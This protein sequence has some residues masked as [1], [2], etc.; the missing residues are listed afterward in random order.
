VEALPGQRRRDPGLENRRVDRLGEVVRG[1]HLEAADDAVELVDAGDHDDRQVLQGGVRS[2]RRQH[3]VAVHLRHDDVEEDHVDRRRGRVAEALERFASVR[4]LDR[5]MA[6]PP[7]Q[8]REQLPVEGRVVDDED[9]PGQGDAVA[10]GWGHAGPPVVAAVAAEV[11]R[12]RAIAASSSS[13]RMG[14]LT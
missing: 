12:A 14:L 6:D 2:E 9:S 7:Q 5:L 4:G 8:L 10:G 13:G 3:L 1:A 11:G